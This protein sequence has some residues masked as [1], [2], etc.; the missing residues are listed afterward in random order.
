MDINTIMSR[1][2][3]QVRKIACNEQGVVLKCQSV[4]QR[5]IEGQLKVHLDHQF[6]FNNFLYT[7]WGNHRKNAKKRPL[8]R[9]GE[10]PFYQAISYHGITA[11]TAET[12]FV[13]L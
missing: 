3:W 11:P 2:H 6:N 9:G 4:L 7:G 8:P 10:R 5:T 13:I 1:K 12:A